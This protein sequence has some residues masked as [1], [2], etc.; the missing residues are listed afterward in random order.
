MLGGMNAERRPVSEQYDPG[1]FPPFAV[2]VDVVVLTIEGGE[3]RVL[4]VERGGDPYR[5]AWA[6]PGGFVRPGEDLDGA[7]RR[8]LSEETAV[9]AAGHLEQLRAYGSPDRDP[10]MR[11]VTVAYLAFIRRV[12]PVAVG[13]DAARAE[14]VPV[15]D[16]LS[17]PPERELAFDHLRIARDALAR[18]RERLA[19]T[20]LATALVGPEFTLA[21]LRGV[22]EA[23][24]DQQLNPGNFRRKVLAT[25]GFVRP[26]GRARSAARATPAE[27]YTAGDTVE[28][29]PPFRIDAPAARDRIDRPPPDLVQSARSPVD[30]VASTPLVEDVAEMRATDTT[31]MMASAP[32][33]AR[34]RS[35]PARE[36]QV[37]RIRAWDDADLQRS[38]L[39]EGVIAIGGDE[40]GDLSDRP[41]SAEIRARLRTAPELAGRSDAAI[42]RFVAYWRAFLGEIRTGDYLLVPLTRRRVAVGRI[43]GSYRYRAGHP[44]PRLQHARPVEWLLTLHRDGLDSDLRKRVDAPGTV[45]RVRLPDAAARVGTL[46]ATRRQRPRL[47]TR[48]KDAG[49]SK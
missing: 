4:L 37:W 16:V 49:T 10:R 17:E 32:A 3:L 19:S 21:E 48:P 14:L 33:G 38:M 25:E 7:A 9:E 15:R 39:R 1:A 13:T 5:G 47:P 8:E 28:L 23:A 34:P 36:R 29:R 46:L 20:S 41:G 27:I 24:W 26:T 42:S 44:N 43:A 22:Y 6:L 30:D 45:A 18:A 2:T 31:A 35:A 12:G 40:I 11:V